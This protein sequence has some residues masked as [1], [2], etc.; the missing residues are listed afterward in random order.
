MSGGKG[1]GPS[2]KASLQ[3]TK[4]GEAVVK[5]RA[6]VWCLPKVLRCLSQLR[7]GSESGSREFRQVLDTSE[8]CLPSAGE[9][10]CLPWC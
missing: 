8:E 3:K 7:R 6:P 1:S 10:A 2:I 9:K 5:L 4:I